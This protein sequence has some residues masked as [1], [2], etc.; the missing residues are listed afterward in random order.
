MAQAN[1]NAT[2]DF[3]NQV[4]GVKSPSEFVKCRLRMP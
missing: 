1:T 2:F 4:L 3:V